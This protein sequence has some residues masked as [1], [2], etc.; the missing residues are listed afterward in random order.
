MLFENVREFNLAIGTPIPESPT[1]PC[2]EDWRLAVSL[3][4]EEWRETIQ[5]W[6]RGDIEAFADGLADLKYVVERIN[7][8]A[9]I[10]SR[11]VDAA[12][13]AANM[14]KIGGPV[15]EDGKQLKPEGWR[16]PDIGA[17]LAARDFWGARGGDDE[18]HT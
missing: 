7:V 18:G 4:H 17:A 8:I 10:D 2:A 6:R 16:P 12:V 14:A 9:G 5:A 3:V 1:L 11:P 13:H 15:R